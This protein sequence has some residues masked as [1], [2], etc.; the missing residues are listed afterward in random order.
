MNEY[1]DALAFIKVTDYVK[2]DGSVDVSETLQKLIDENPNRTIYFPD[3]TYLLGSPIRT[4]A[5]P[6]KSVDLALSNYAVLKAVEGWKHDAAMVCLGGKDPKNDIRTVGSNYG[7]R[8]GI[9]DGSGVA[10]GISIDGGRETKIHNVSIKNT[11][12]GIHIKY[13]ANSGSSDDDIS[14]VNIVGNRAR[15]SIGVLVE[16]FDNTFTNMRIAHVFIGVKLCSAGN[17]LRCI[18]PLYTLDYTDYENSAAFLDERGNN[19][20]TNCY[21]DQFGIG[22]RNA[23][24]MKSIYDGCYCYWYSPKGGKHVAFK[25]D[26]AFSSVL[27]NFRS[28]FRKESGVQRILLDVKE[29]GGKGVFDRLITDPDRID[30]TAHLPYVKGEI[31]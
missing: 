20:Y 1:S 2:A 8:G 18:H 21:S 16:G 30:D 12:I 28:D 29:A 25:C 23:K 14:D 4:P 3:G 19:W 7:F 17:F 31:I 5:D 24:T 22:F 11:R 9:V 6:Q 26:G 15:D 13:G 10:D 27:T